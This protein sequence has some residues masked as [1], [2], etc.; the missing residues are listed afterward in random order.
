MLLVLGALY[1]LIVVPLVDLHAANAEAIE[2]RR[3]MLARLNAI[4]GE[5]PALRAR[6]AELQRTSDQKTLLLDGGSDALASAGLQSRIGEIAAQAGL[7]VGSVESIPPE[8]QGQYRRLGLR[9]TLNGQYEG[10]ARL[11]AGLEVAAPP[12]IVDNMQIYAVQR[13]PGAAAVAASAL[14]AR[15]EVFGFRSDAAD[16]ATR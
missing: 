15:L 12:L 13:R 1:L 11:L 8:L 3:A 14:D 10:L 16:T 2:A 9:L 5:V 7:T 6:L 4:S